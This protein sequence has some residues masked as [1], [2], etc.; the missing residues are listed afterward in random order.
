MAGFDRSFVLTVID[1]ATNVATNFPKA[2]TVG[3]QSRSIQTSD[4]PERTANLAGG[5][6]SDTQ[7]AVDSRD[8]GRGP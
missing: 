8:C 5:H 3:L 4:Q 1:L 7:G 2:T 6:V